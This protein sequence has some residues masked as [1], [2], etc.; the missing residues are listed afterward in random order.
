ML[1]TP[2]LLDYD[3]MIAAPAIAFLAAHG[4]DRGFAPYEKSALALI[5]IAPLVTRALAEQIFLP[6]GLVAIIVLFVL[7]L[8]RSALDRAAPPASAPAR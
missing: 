2:Y 5:W 3:L 7:P 4:L 8:R 1:A 6:I